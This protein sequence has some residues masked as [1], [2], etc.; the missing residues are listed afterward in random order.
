M[1]SSHEKE[2]VVAWPG[3]S[4]FP[5]LLSLLTLTDQ[6]ARRC[7][8]AYN[9]TFYL[10]ELKS[11]VRTCCIHMILRYIQEGFPSHS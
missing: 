8:L 4:P 10:S 9:V 7:Q 6:K 2:K 3:A 11:K 1:C 5:E